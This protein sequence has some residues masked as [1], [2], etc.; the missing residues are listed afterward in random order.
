MN[1]SANLHEDLKRLRDECVRGAASHD[2]NIYVLG[3]PLPDSSSEEERDLELR[4]MFRP[5][6][7]RKIHAGPGYPSEFALGSAVKFEARTTVQIERNGDHCEFGLVL[8]DSCFPPRHHRGKANL[9]EAFEEFS[10]FA[11]QAGSILIAHHP[12]ETARDP[13]C[14]WIRRLFHKCIDTS[15]ANESN[16]GIR[17]RRVWAASLQTIN[18]LIQQLHDGESPAQSTGAPAATPVGQSQRTKSSGRNSISHDR[19]KEELFKAVLKKHHRF[20]HDPDDF[21]G[22][23]ISTRAVEVVSGHV[24]S[25]TTA[26]RLFKKHFGGVKEYR[27]ACQDETIRAKLTVVLGEGLAALRSVDPT[28]LADTEASPETDDE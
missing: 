27:R 7:R 1:R 3:V 10:R 24:L 26:G 28:V 12:E 13:R 11:R 21:N 6:A 20:D 22:E 19:T 8:V 25:D 18:A 23:P 14:V 16:D 4:A 17:V 2:A 15:F 5:R 9:D